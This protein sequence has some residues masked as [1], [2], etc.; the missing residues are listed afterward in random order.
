[1]KF[2]FLTSMRFPSYRPV[3]IYMKSMAI[4]FGKVLGKDFTF[5]TA[6]PIRDDFKGAQVISINSKERFRAVFYFI[7]LPFFVI[8][9]KYNNKNTV[10]FSP[11]PYLSVTL[12]FY[13]KIFRFKYK[14]FS[15]W[16]MLFGDWRDKYIAVN[17]NYLVSTTKKIK[18]I[19]VKKTGVS[20]DKVLVSYGGVDVEIFKNTG[21]SV[22]E[23]RHRLSLPDGFLVGYVG[24]YKTMGMD[25][26]VP[27]MIKS[28]TDIPDKNIKMV[29]VG[30]IDN[31]EIDEY[32]KIAKDLGVLDRTIFLLA[33]KTNQVPAYEQAMDML[34]IPYPDQPHFRE[35]GFPMKIYEYMFSGKPIIYSNL[36]IIDEMLF[37]CGVSFI[38]DDP[39]D[40]AK[41]IIDL[42]KDP[43]KINNLSESAFQKV[44]GFTWEK[45]AENIVNFA[46]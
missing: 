10:F 2:V 11:D 5:V 22:S 14:V 9:K 42:N 17:S 28:L 19:L 35:Y 13:R 30:G 23:L 27:T 4:A 40:L 20:P 15:D 7:Y 29:F 36:P 12:I 39:K 34:V 16:H 37:D 46:K 25:K 8:H 41:K 33:V 18:D 38:P 32:K 44:Q 43:Q 45:R 26:G 31:K 21:E 24:F 6:G 1:M 3:Y